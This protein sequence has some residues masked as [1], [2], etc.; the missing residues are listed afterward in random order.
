MMVCINVSGLKAKALAKMD[1]I[2]TTTVRSYFHS[3][4]D[5]GLFDA[6]QLALA[7]RLRQIEEFE[8]RPPAR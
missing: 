5:A 6:I 2:W 3:R 7:M 8:A 1:S 4:R